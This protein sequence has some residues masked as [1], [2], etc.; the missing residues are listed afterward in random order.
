MNES[1][2]GGA[3]GS[4]CAEG[5][6]LACA[7]ASEIMKLGKKCYEPKE[8]E[9]LGL[10]PDTDQ[11]NAI[12]AYLGLVQRDNKVA[13]LVPEAEAEQLFL[14]HFCDSIQLLLLFGFK[15]NATVFD[16]GSGGGFP[17]VPIRIFRPD[18]SF[19]L[20]ES[21][22]EKA[23]FL[24]EVKAALNLGNVEIHAGK[25]ESISPEKKADYVISRGVGT[26]QK[27]AQLAKPLLVKDGRMYTYKAKQLSAELDVITA[28]KDKYG[29]K[30]NEIAQY[31]LGS[32]IQGLNLVSMGIM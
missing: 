4:A 18:L 6:N 19:T 29:I 27:F 3:G 17:A 1:T 22:R 20:I 9:R 21:S 10:S 11:R 7:P 5:N 31:D 12:L 30:I 28:N 13:E 32:L 26:L 24:S 15:K 2:G 23:A 8:L 25:A 14:R 16:I